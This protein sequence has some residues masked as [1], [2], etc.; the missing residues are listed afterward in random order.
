LVMGFSKRFRDARHGFPLRVPLLCCV[1][2]GQ[3]E[4]EGLG[5]MYGGLVQRQTMHRGPQI[6]DVALGRAGRVEALKHVLGEVHRK[7]TL[8]GGFAAVQ[9]TRTALLRT[10]AMELMAAAQV[11]EN[12]FHADLGPKSGK[13]DTFGSWERRVGV[14]CRYAAVVLRQFGGYR[15][16][17]R[18]DHFPLRACALLVVARGFFVGRRKLGVGPGKVLRIEGPTGG[19]DG[20]DQ[21]EQFAHAMPQGHVAA[22]AAGAQAAIQTADGGVV[23]ARGFGSI[24]Q[25]FPHQVVAFAGHVRGPAGFGPAVLLDA[26]RVGLGKDAEIADEMAGSAEAVAGDHFGG[27]DGGGG[28]AD[29]GDGD[30]VIGNGQGLIGLGH[31]FLE[32]GL[33]AQAVAELRDQLSD[34]IG[35]NSAGETG[36]GDGSVGLDLVGFVVG[37]VRDARQGGTFGAGDACRS[38]KGAEQAQDPGGLE[39]GNAHGQFGKDAGEEV[40]ELVGQACGQTRLAFEP[41]DNLAKV[42]DVG[43]QRLGGCGV[44]EES[45]AGG[46]VA[47]G[48]V[49]LVLRENCFAVVLI[50]NGLA[51]GDGL[52]EGKV[53]EKGL[54]VGGVLAGDVEAD[55]E[56]GGGEALLHGKEKLEEALVAGVGFGEL[57]GRAEVL[58]VAIEKGDVVAEACGIDADADGQGLGSE[59]GRVVH[60]R[61]LL[62]RGTSTGKPAAARVLREEWTKAILVMNGR[63]VRCNKA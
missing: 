59:V 2:C 36:D 47:F 32:A 48:G 60:G 35:S 1:A 33:G 17:N 29:A 40:V 19:P 38:G 42:D 51:E 58:E 37:E 46:A 26:G 4:V 61:E 11:R 22:F 39:I 3:G 8:P 53:V 57:G 56:M 45:E 16:R 14:G 49:G 27:E 21:V 5:Q 10:W 41:G 24:P 44:F 7:R 31:E 54:E 63:A 12:L 15:G 9:R 6:E 30:E 28:V 55:A 43:G 18:G 34:E 20:E 50:T 13:V 62:R 25:I 52:G 23:H